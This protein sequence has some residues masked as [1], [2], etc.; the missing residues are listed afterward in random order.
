MDGGS[1]AG[2]NTLNFNADG[3]AVTIQG[4]QITAAGQQP[5]TFS[6]FA[7]V[8]ILNPTGAGSVTLDATAGM[9]DA[10][11]LTGTGPE[12]GTFTLN[13]S[14]PTF[15]FSGVN[16]FAYN[17]GTMTEAITVT[18]FA[19]PVLQWGVALT[20]NGGTGTAT[21][22][23]NSVAGVSDNITVQPSA[24]GA[25]QLIDTNAAT[26]TS[27]AVVTYVHTKNFVISGNNTGATGVTDNLFIDGTQGADA[28][29]VNDAV[30][31]ANAVNVN[32]YLVV[33]Y[34]PSLPHLEID[35]LAGSDTF[36]VEPSTT[37]TFL[38]NGGDPIA[39]QPGDTLNLIHPAGALYVINP[40][41]TSDAGGLNTS[42][43]QTVSWVQIETLANTGAGDAASGPAKIQGTNGN[44]IITVIATGAQS[45]TVSINGGNAMAFT[46][47][48]DLF[49]DTLAGN[50]VVDVKIPALT[51]AG[52]AFVWNVQV[53][54][55]G[56]GPESGG[57]GL[58]DTIELDASS[59]QDVTYTPNFAVTGLPAVT[60]VTFTQ[61]ATGGGQFSDTEETS[62]ITATGFLYGT[63]TSPPLE[64]SPSAGAESFVYA[65]EG[66]NGSLT[67]QTSHAVLATDHVIYT[68]GATADAGAITGTQPGGVGGSALATLTFTG[69]GTTATVSF[70]AL[71]GGQILTVNGTPA[72]DLFFVNGPADLGDGTLQLFSPTAANPTANPSTNLPIT[73]LINLSNVI[74]LNLKGNG[75]A[76]DI[77]DVVGPLLFSAGITLDGDATADLSGASGAVTVNLGDASVPTNTTVTGFGATVTLIGVD[78]ANLNA[79]SQTIE[80]VGT[81]QNDDF[82]YTPTGATAG[83]FYDS[84]ASGNNLVPNTVFNISN[85]SDEFTVDGGSGGNADAVTLEGTAA[86]DLIEINQATE[87]AQVLA[88]NVTALL[89]IQ[90]D[91]DVEVLNAEGGT[92]QN[93]F[94]VIP[95]AGLQGSI[96]NL[97]VN[98]DGGS[99]GQQNALVVADSFG[100]SPG[101]LPSNYFVVVNKYLTPGSGTV[102]VFQSAAADP[103]INYTNIQTVVPYP[104]QT[105]AGN[106]NSNLLVM[107]PDPYEPNDNQG[108]ATFLGS[109]ATINVPVAA[110]FPNDAE[111]PGVPAD[112][113]WYQV[114]AQN[115]GTLDFEV[116]FKTFSTS[117]LPGGGQL[118]AQ[119]Y[120]ANGDLIGDAAFGPTDF[121]ATASTGD[122][123]VRIP[124][125]AGQ[126]YFLRIF[127]ANVSPGNEVNGTANGSVING[128]SV[129]IINTPPPTPFNLELSRS[130]L[131]VTGLSGGS[132][133]TSA[134]TVTINGTGTGAVGTAYISSGAVIAVTISE[135]TGYTSA[136]TISFSAPPVGGTTAT[137]NVAITDTGDEPANTFNDDSGRSQFDSVT[138]VNEPL[139]YIHLT[140]GILLN[141][142][143]GNGS[144]SPTGVSANNPPVGQIPILWS[145]VGGANGDTNNAGFR[146]AIFDGLDSQNPVGFATPVGA[147]YPGLYAYTFTSPLADGIHNIYASVEMVDP[148]NPQETGFGPLSTIPLTLTID[149]V[150]PPVFFGSTAEED[151]V[152]VTMLAQGS[153]YTSVPNVT[154]SGG[155]G[156]VGATATAILGTGSETGEVVGILITGG[157]AFTSAPSIAID[158]P[159]I[160]AGATQAVAVAVVSQPSRAGSRQRRIPDG[161]KRPM[162]VMP[163]WF[164]SA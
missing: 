100:T 103:D 20:I 90:L 128:Y 83:T 77:F 16:S 147:A 66:G 14:P 80:A 15:A 29:D 109:G 116:Y 125:V 150:P 149:T 113:D 86:R 101:T 12:A 76:S 124:A 47:T 32:G 129:T 64:T 136:T 106:A 145:A 159:P 50:D 146:V 96:D 153:G 98:I 27:I 75:G 79:N 151:G 160:G 57:A 91:T 120:D 92:G 163:S 18:P 142:L 17:G 138:N 135:G 105:G 13:G 70:T 118:D 78:T 4:D 162:S 139:I 127:G 45:F 140:D 119:V 132:G 104:S 88:N 61:P 60:N 115:T 85:V 53:F 99:G 2:T 44:D 11:V 54:I 9:D 93:T 55:A 7:A 5:V 25:G 74:G 110:I 71:N 63:N 73:D 34:N 82:I 69:I 148:A 134:P 157:T 81:S 155:A 21:L 94:Q 133:Y 46:G 37:T 62:T 36:N 95:G 49:I 35:G 68:P 40:G 89:P 102:R 48:P 114:V 33:N 111:F 8:N 23:F 164:M 1:A 131:T 22:T 10:M 42:G 141:D 28:I 108:E 126:S 84:I 137:A 107:G 52:A 59:S 152:A 19:T 97:L 161:M 87:T 67:Y 26:S 123:R 30:S 31:G 3:L 112:Q 72:A 144:N 41:P 38:I 158:P 51:P 6:N 65:G 39:V 121:G 24:A 154:L 117:L 143:Q 56:Q 43:Y 58:G 130:V 122:A 156:G